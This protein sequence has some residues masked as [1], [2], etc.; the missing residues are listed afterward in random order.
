MAKRLCCRIPS[1]FLQPLCNPFRTPPGNAPLVLVT[2][3]YAP[4][5]GGVAIYVQEIAS[6]AWQAGETVEVWTVDYRRRLD[7]QQTLQRDALDSSQTFP[8]V[9]LRSTGRLTPGGLLTFAWG[10]LRRRRRLETSPVVLMSVGAQMVFFMLGALG[11]APARRVTVFLYGS[12]LLRF[13]RSRVWRG[14]ARRFYAR[15]AGFAVLTRPIERLARESGLLPPGASIVLA[16]GALPSAFVRHAAATA[17]AGGD[18]ERVRVLT[19]ARL[20]PRKG[21]RE[22]ARALA[23]LPAA[24]RERL[25]YQMVGV[26]DEAYRREVETACRE[27]GVPCEFLGAVD[28][29]AIGAVYR[30]ATVYVQASVTLPNS[31]EGFGLSF[32]EASFHGC[33]VAAYRSGGVTEAVAN[34]ETGL[35]VPEGDRAALADAVGRLLDDPALRGQL[36]EAGRAFARGFRWEKSARVLCEA[37]RGGRVC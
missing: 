35:L 32:L 9:R 17:A 21:Q 10:I 25:V 6:A 24:Q 8:V 19:V 1:P 27:G 16:P 11:I 5:R 28:D 14:L 34:G 22:V 3:E 29:E 37:A 23:L 31:I 18:D 36:G 12:E 15:A 33:P 2:H 7:G 20:H 30:R 26:G 13:G 4:F